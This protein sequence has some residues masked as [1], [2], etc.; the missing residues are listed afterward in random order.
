MMIF[1]KLRLTMQSSEASE[2]A[3][4]VKKKEYKPRELKDF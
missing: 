1:L 4:N 3:K 2:K